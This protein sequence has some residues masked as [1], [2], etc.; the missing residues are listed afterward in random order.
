MAKRVEDFTFS[1]LTKVFNAGDSAPFAIE[2][3]LKAKSYDLGPKS[4]KFEKQDEWTE[5]KI[6]E[7]AKTIS[8][9]KG[10]G[11]NFDD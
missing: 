10:P 9:D 5:A 2:A 4:E 11:G 8:A 6:R 3:L 7:K 1:L